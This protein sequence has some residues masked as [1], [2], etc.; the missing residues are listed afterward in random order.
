[1]S[2][3]VKNRIKII[4]NLGKERA[5]DYFG[6]LMESGMT[7]QEQNNYLLKLLQELRNNMDSERFEDPMMRFGVDSK[8]LLGKD[9]KELIELMV[10]EFPYYKCPVGNNYC[11]SGKICEESINGY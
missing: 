2:E 8:L 4:I 11:S 9:K 10:G 1:M 6:V 3:K 5:L 7:Q